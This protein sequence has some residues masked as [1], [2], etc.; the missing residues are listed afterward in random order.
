MSSRSWSAVRARVGRHPGPELGLEQRQHGVPDADPGERRVGVVRVLP[1]LEALDLAGRHGV[2]AGDVEQRPPVARR[3]PGACRRA[4]GRPSPGRAPAARSPPGRRGCARAA[5]R[6]A[7]RSA[8]CV[9]HGVPRVAGPPPPGPVRRRRR[10]TRTAQR[11]RRRRAPAICGR[12]PRGAL[13]RA[14]LQPVVD[15]AADD[16]ASRPARPRT[17]VGGEQGQRVGAAGAGDH[18]GGAGRPRSARQRRTATADGG[19]GRVQAHR[20]TAVSRG[21]GRPRRPGRRS[22]PWWAGSR[23]GPDGVEARPCPPCRRP[24]RTNTAPSRYCASWRRCRAAGG[25]AGRARRRPCGAGRTCARISATLGM[26][27]G[28]TPSMTTSAWP[29]SSDMTPVSWSTIARCSGVLQQVE[30]AAAVSP[31]DA[32]RPS[33]LEAVAS[34]RRAPAS[35]SVASTSAASRRGGGRAATAPR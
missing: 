13:G 9:E 11:S 16:A 20:P 2:G 22:R 17:T 30:Q 28:P 7:D 14:R 12:R 24:P 26:T 15:V 27:S 29:S 32:R 34:R 1:D 6:R 25:A 10:A 18:D 4:S 31:S 21:R 35:S 8:T 3:R 5:P 33:A 23:G 19:D